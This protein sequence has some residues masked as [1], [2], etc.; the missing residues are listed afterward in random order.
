[1]TGIKLIFY[2]LFLVYRIFYSSRQGQNNRMNSK[3][4]NL[5]N[6][7]EVE[8]LL[9]SID[10]VLADCD[11]VIYLN[12]SVVPGTPE[13]LNLLRANGKKIIFASNNSSKSRKSVLT[14]LNKMGFNATLDEVIVSSFVVAEYLK[15]ID[16]K[17]KV[18][19]FGCS[20][21]KDE[22]DEMDIENDGVGPDPFPESFDTSTLVPPITLDPSIR[23][24]VVAFDSL[25]SLP[26]LIKVGCNFLQIS[27]YFDLK[28]MIH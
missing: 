23:A 16:F 12:N 7:Q 13:T 15:S 26:K 19:V 6:Q 27:R 3:P 14:K 20:G 25:I 24:V 9:S 2:L 11:G 5:D 4:I 8:K 22:L 1:M 28:Q 17:G 21:V 18:Y 10:Y